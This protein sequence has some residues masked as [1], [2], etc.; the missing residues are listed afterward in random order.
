MKC[1][2]CRTDLFA[3]GGLPTESDRSIFTVKRHSPEPDQIENNTAGTA[4]SL[5]PENRENA[6]YIQQYNYFIQS[7]LKWSLL[8]FYHIRF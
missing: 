6:E 3:S 2:N 5:K 4:D 8:C 1:P 7:L